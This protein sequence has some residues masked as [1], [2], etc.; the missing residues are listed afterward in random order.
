L[1]LRYLL[2]TS[3]V[4]AV[5]APKPNRGVLQR[6]ARR[7]QQCAIASVVWNELVY[8][9]HRLPSGKRRTELEAFLQH[10]VARSFPILPYDESAA[11]WHGIERARQEQVGRPAP[12]VDGQIA[13]VAL[14]NN[15]IL[16]TAN[17]KDFGGKFSGLDVEDWTAAGRTR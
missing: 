13:A 17:V 15:L 2:D 11:T 7:E 5:I 14:V 3:T 10:V 4:S 1:T 6:I 9:C 12:Y 8:G 16:V